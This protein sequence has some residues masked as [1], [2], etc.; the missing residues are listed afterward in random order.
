MGGYDVANDLPRESILAV[1]WAQF[2]RK[3]SR[4][5]LEAMSP[6]DVEISN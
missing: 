4:G 2:N 6:R 5:D 3:M 1:R